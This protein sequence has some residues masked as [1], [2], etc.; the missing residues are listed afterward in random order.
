MILVIYNWYHHPIMNKPEKRNGFEEVSTIKDAT[1]FIEQLKET[2]H[3]LGYK[4]FD[5]IKII[6]GKEVKVAC[7]T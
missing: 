5:N 7:V 4:M 2:N 6:D 3:A 1:M